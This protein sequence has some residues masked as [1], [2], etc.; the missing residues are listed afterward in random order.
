MKFPVVIL[1]IIFIVFIALGLPDALLGASWNLSRR[2]FG[3]EIGAIGY[4]TF[5]S[6]LSI[7]L[8]TFLAPYALMVVKTQRI[9]LVSLLM[10]G[11]AL[12]FI[13]QVERYRSL[14]LWAIPLGLGSGMIDL[15]LQ[16]Y[17]ASRLKAR[18]MN[19]LHFA[20][21]IGVTTGPF[22]MAGALAFFTWRQGYIW[23]GSFLIV[24]ASLVLLS[25]KWWPDPA[26]KHGPNGHNAPLKATFHTPGVK[27]SIAIFLVAVHVES[28]IG[29]FMA[30]YAFIVLDLSASV[31]AL[32]TTTFFVGLTLIRGISGTLGDRVAPASW[33]KAGTFGLLIGAGLL[34]LSSWV[35]YLAF[36]SF[37]VLGISMGP[38]YP[39]M[40]QMNKARFGEEKLSRVMSLQMVIGYTG[41]GVFTPLAGQWFE[42][43]SMGALPY[44]IGAL[45]L[46]LIGLTKSYLKP[47]KSVN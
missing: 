27:H 42:R 43:V 3:V 40:M 25:F 20:Y 33:V 10:M 15:S 23:V 17:V 16:H 44:F 22:L 46:V 26:K 19:F 45:G 2:A 13:S 32:A 7:L 35:S 34:G 9:L 21:G 18:H 36:I 1:S 47:L 12:I 37:F 4:F 14:L 39:N 38:V 41:F 29:V 31:A 30:S 6:Y 8:A 5:V 11:L 28:M 24:I